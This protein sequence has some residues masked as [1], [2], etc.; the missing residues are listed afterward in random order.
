MTI[1][2]DKKYV[3]NTYS[4]FPI[5]LVKGEGVKVWDKD[6]KEYLDFVGG[7]AVN[8][9][10][11]SHQAV[12]NAIKEQ[13]DKLIHCSNLYWTENQIEL[14]KLICENSFGKSVFFC[15]SGA[16]A[17]EGAI[18]LARKYGNTKYKGKRYKIITA[19]NSFHG[20]TYGALTAT[21]QIKYHNGFEPLLDGFVYVDYND[22]N[23]LQSAVDENTC[24]IMLEVIQ[25]EGGVNEADSNYLKEVKNLCEKN[26]LLLIFDEVQTG[27]GR[28][29]K[30][31]A[32][33]H[34][35]V[36]PDVMT[37]AKAL[38]G[39]VPIG[40]LVVNE[41]ADIFVPGNHASTF[42]GNPLACAAGKIVM[43]IISQK[44]FLDEVKEKGEYFKGELEKLKSKFSIIKKVKGKGLM[45]GVELDTNDGSKIVKKSMEKGLLINVI[46]HNILR[47]VPPLIISKKEIKDGI[48]ILKDVFL[49]MNS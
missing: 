49:E 26:D 28:T 23:S 10:G 45:L 35:G 17:N 22:L 30:L 11:H 6:G 8:A 5:T 20:R 14:A 7:I 18:K 24:A 44:S 13:A 47:F 36:V 29:G 34:S 46:N 43:N 42:G 38:G 9:L 16:E 37:L 32:Y 3:M 27:I 19:K 4:R 31:F 15:N 1:S 33:E 41:K 39:G 25:G 21:G 40:A 12:V 2:E 48:E